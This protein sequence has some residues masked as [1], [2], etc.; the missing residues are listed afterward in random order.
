MEAR[1][2]E[3]TFTSKD[4]YNKLSV[5]AAEKAFD[6]SGFLDVLRKREQEEG[7]FFRYTED[8]EGCLDKVNPK[9]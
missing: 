9:H 6:A 4:V 3:V 2:L 1:G 7:L 8:E 5:S